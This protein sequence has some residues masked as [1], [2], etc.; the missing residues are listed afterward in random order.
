M[1]PCSPPLS[2]VFEVLAREG[3]FD[4]EVV[5]F[6]FRRQCLQVGDVSI[7]S[8]WDKY[9]TSGLVPQRLRVQ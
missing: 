4:A 1:P 7:V 6:E 8:A 9:G 2:F 5:N 3:S